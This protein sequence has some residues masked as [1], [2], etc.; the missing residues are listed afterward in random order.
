MSEEDGTLPGI[1]VTRPSIARVYDYLLGGKDNYI[2]DRELGDVFIKKIP[3]ARIIAYDNRRALVRAVREMS[4]AGVRQFI[5]V[6]SGLPTADN[7]HQVARR[8]AED[9]RVVYVDNDPMALAHA[10]ALLEGDGLT[11]VIDADLRDPA[12]IRDHEATRELLDFDE[13]VAVVLSGILHH[14]NDDEDPA[15]V[16]RYWR[17]SVAPGSFF[18]ITHFRRAEGT[19][20]ARLEEILQSSLGRGRWR[21]DA[22]LHALFDGLILLAPGIVPSA[23]WRPEPGAENAELTSWQLLIATGL[24]VKP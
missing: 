7:V 12:G 5:D 13:P 18:L 15:G 6:G 22:E 9:P 14:L 24:A 11:T 8:H 3:G 21:T 1:D 23:R 2:V 4:R 20:A 17:E 10:R 16:M 19:E